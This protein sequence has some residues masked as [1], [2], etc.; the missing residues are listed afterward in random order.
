AVPL[1]DRPDGRPR[2]PPLFLDPLQEALQERAR[3]EVPVMAWP[4]PPRRL[5]RVSAQAYN[6][7]DQY[8]RL[9]DTVRRFL[10]EEL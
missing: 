7:P 4:A 8:E 2:R 6:A 9:A 5:L 1:P 3:V 10:A